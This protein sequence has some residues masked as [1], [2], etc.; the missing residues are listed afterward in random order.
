MPTQ[1]G[2]PIA[3]LCEK[4]SEA[5]KNSSTYDKE[6]Y[7]IIKALKHWR[8]YMIGGE[9]ILHSNLEALKFLQG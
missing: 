2:K 7:A 5:R 8:Q 4:V 3:Y 9:F 6:F 1:E